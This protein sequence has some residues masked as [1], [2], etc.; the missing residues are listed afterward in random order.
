MTSI[1]TLLSL[2]IFL[3]S[4]FELAENANETTSEDYPLRIPPVL[5]GFYEELHKNRRPRR[6]DRQSRQLVP[7]VYSCGHQVGLYSVLHE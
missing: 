5:L 7:G 4:S 1:V 2:A 3:A 6:S